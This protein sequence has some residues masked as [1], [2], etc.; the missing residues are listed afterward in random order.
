MRL[1]FSSSFFKR[2][3]NS[4]EDLKFRRFYGLSEKA[5]G[6]KSPR[7]FGTGGAKNLE[8]IFI[9]WHACLWN[10]VARGLSLFDCL[11]GGIYRLEMENLK[12]N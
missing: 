9:A 6:S 1:R 2:F 8:D 4:L 5:E 10:D 11:L 3:L 12:K 7:F